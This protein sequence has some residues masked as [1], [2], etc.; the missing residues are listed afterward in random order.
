[1]G[2]IPDINERKCTVCG[3]CV[4]HCPTGA[5]AVIDGKA[6]IVRPEDCNF[7]TQCE[8]VCP[9]GAVQCYFEI[10]LQEQ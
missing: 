7:C 5:K 6:K 4:E 1:M 10:V 9:S 2:R 8:A 3:E